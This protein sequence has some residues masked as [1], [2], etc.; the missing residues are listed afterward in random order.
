MMEQYNARF[1]D[2]PTTELLL[3]ANYRP[4]ERSKEHFLRAADILAD[5][6]E[7][8]RGADRPNMKQL[9]RALKTLR[10]EYGAMDGVRGWYAE[11]VDS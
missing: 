9:T 8:T 1:Q 3:E 2:T 7:R 10:Y 4:A 6:Q 11:R 5:L